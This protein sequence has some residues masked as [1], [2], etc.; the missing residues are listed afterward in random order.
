MTAWPS[1]ITVEGS[2]ASLTQLAVASV[3][4][5]EA[6]GIGNLTYPYKPIQVAISVRRGDGFLLREN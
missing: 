6:N 2:S 1:G 3:Y 5:Q 4:L